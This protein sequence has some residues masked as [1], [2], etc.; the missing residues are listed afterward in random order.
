MASPI[1]SSL[2]WVF[3]QNLN[4]FLSCWY[5]LD[6]GHL[7]GGRRP[8]FLDINDEAHHTVGLKLNGHRLEVKQEPRLEFEV[9]C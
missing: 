3:E 5:F 2:C 7:S 8:I 6:F 9:E 1:T 4:S